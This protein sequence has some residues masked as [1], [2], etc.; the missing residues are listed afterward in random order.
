MNRPNIL[1]IC[2]DQ[3]RADGLGCAGNPIVRTPNIDSIAANGTRFTRH[4]TPM[5]MCSP[6]RGTLM[7]GLYPRHHGLSTNGRAL[8]DDVPTLPA[9]LSDS[10]YRTHGVG[11]QHLQPLLAPAELNMPDS[12]AFWETPE[13]QDWNGPYY[14]FQTLDM[15]LGE[16]DTAHL[17][18]HY[19][20]W[21]QD[22]HPE[23]RELLKPEHASEPL[24]SDLDEI[25]RSA[26]PVAA[27]YNTW[28]SQRAIDFFEQESQDDKP[29]FMFV[30][31]ADPHHPFYPPAAYAD[32]YNPADMPLPVVDATDL[33]SRPPYCDEL[34]PKGIGF[35]ERY[36]VGDQSLE[37][38]CTLTTES[39]SPES[40]QAR[41]PTPTA[42]SR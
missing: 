29:F 35:R 18:G 22:H 25:W 37:A 1:W 40:L 19:A 7:S 5:Q 16:S 42:R 28:I 12:R 27:H 9:L 21:L 30:S 36:W 14:G 41:L 39:I 26:M 3:Q 8:P 17:A 23:W 33:A 20:N 38:G 34:F 2:T 31:Y 13:S 11:K 24:P 4:I 32:R 10:G 6:T 15:L